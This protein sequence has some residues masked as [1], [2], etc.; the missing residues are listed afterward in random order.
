MQFLIQVRIIRKY[1]TRNV[2]Y[3]SN[4]WVTVPETVVSLLNLK[5]TSLQV[6]KKKIPASPCYFEGY[7]IIYVCF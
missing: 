4:F 2:N 7:K 3:L 5:L 6:L 1:F